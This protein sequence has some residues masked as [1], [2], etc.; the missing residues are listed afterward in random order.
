[1]TYKTELIE[2]I[3]DSEKWPAHARPDFLNE[4][5]EGADEV[6]AKASIEGYLASV[7]IYHQISEEM[8]KVLLGCCDFF[9]QLAVSPA[10]IK[11]QHSDKRMFG[12]LINDLEK[13]VSFESK[14]AF[15][16]KCKEL[17]EVRIR[18]VHR[19]TRKSSLK[20]IKKQSSKIK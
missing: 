16:V 2:R 13:T 14:E 12:Q 9:I 5:N 3:K 7:L 1:M 10:E 15:I 19:L 17:N 4:L 18:I 11:F 20:D 6:F 8:I